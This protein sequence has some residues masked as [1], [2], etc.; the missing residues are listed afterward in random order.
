MSS[1]PISTVDPSPIPSAAA[2]YATGDDSALVENRPVHKDEIDAER[3]ALDTSVRTPVLLFFGAALH[4]LLLAS[5]LAILDSF[6]LNFPS[7]LTEYGFLTIGRLHPAAGNALVYG[8]AGTAGIG[9]SLWLMARLCRTPF[10]H[11]GVL[12]AAWAVWNLGVALGVFGILYGHGTSYLSLEFPRYASSLI[13]T[14]FV[15]IALWVVMAFRNRRHGEA[16]ISQWYVLA[17]FLFFPWSYATANLL[18]FFVPMQAPAQAVIA[19]WYAH[20]LVSMFFVPLGLALA[21]YIVPKVLGEPIANYRF[22]KLGFWTWLLFAGLSGAYGLIG[23]PL[24]TWMTSLAIA[25]SILTL[26]PLFSILATFRNTLNGRYRALRHVPSIRFAVIGVWCFLA[27]GIVAA[28]TSFRG[29]QSAL[30]FTILGDAAGQLV[31]YGFVTL[32]LFGA[33]YY[34]TSRLLGLEWESPALIRAHF[35]YCI[36][37]FGLATVSLGLGGIIQGLGLDDPKVPNLVLLSFIKPFLFMQLVGAVLV[38]VG[39][40]CLLASFALLV[41][42]IGQP[43]LL[44]PLHVLGEALS[45]DRYAAQTTA[46][47]TPN[48]LSAAAPAVTAK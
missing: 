44:K 40:V 20:S 1:V 48:D 21:Y 33:I 39:H 6:K 7:F 19:A 5:A 34:I 17:A 9:A 24:P 27:A 2:A 10:R 42:R 25:A 22:A 46:A 13:F 29:I 26:V 4:W 16:Y 31:M 32:T 12:E 30:H 28:L 14:A 15:F 23:G 37:G 43:T 35:W 45:P 18:V 41:A 47:P 3:T 36:V 38:T 11:G 8:W